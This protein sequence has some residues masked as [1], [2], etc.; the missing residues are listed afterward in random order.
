MTHPFVSSIESRAKANPRRVV[1]P[2]A[3]FDER[4]L[5]ALIDVAAR[6]VAWPI[7]IVSGGAVEG[8]SQLKIAAQRLGLEWPEAIEVMSVE[9]AAMAPKARE[10]YQQRRAKENLSADALIALMSDPTMFGAALVGLGHADA[11]VSGCITSTADVLRAA[12]KLVGTAPGMKTVSSCFIMIHPD[13]RWGEK[14]LMVFGDCAVLPNP[15]PAQLADIAV[16]SATTAKQLCGIEPRVA[17]LSF[18]TKG[19]AKHEMVEAVVQA[20]GLAKSHAPDLFI[21][22][23]LQVDAAIVEEIGQRKAPGSAIAG[24][25]NV[26]I[27]PDLD[28]GNIGYKLTQRLGGAEAIGPIIQG[29]A[30]PINDLSRGCSWQDISSVVAIAAVMSMKA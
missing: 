29:L 11:M 5:R 27:F 25:A 14:G 18:S 20:T 3:A 4:A 1:L 23:E 30:K 7:A 24:K 9:D 10:L 28:A 26:L 21:D 15:T 19:S 22:G 8:T 12:I 17:M 6:G 13:P 2:E 16:A